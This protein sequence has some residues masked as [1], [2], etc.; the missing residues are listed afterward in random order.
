LS[1]P[2][3]ADKTINLEQPNAD[4]PDHRIIH[5][6]DVSNNQKLGHIPKIQHKLHRSEFWTIYRGKEKI[7]K[8]AED[9]GPSRPA[10]RARSSTWRWS[11]NRWVWN[12]SKA[13]SHALLL[14]FK[15]KGTHALCSS[16]LPLPL[17][18][19]VPRLLI[20]WPSSSWHVSFTPLNMDHLFNSTGTSLFAS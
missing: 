16:C 5:R 13:Y 14:F 20:T 2:K 6:K 15:L 10:A 4:T 8:R 9:S 18:R 12:W 17:F 1:I 3:P 11:R 7:S 19:R